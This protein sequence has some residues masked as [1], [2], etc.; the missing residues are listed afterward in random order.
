MIKSELINFVANKYNNFPRRIIEQVV[1]LFFSE[2]MCSLA[3]HQRVEFRGFGTFA[4][5]KRSLKMVK[6]P[7][8]NRLIDL[9]E[10]YV[11]YF[12]MSKHLKNMVNE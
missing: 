8:T 9:E 6:R 12:R 2:I 5:R 10:Y 1:E 3:K 4:I 7:K 11:N